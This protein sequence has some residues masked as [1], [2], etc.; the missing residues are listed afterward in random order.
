MTYTFKHIYIFIKVWAKGVVDARMFMCPHPVLTERAAFHRLPSVVT[1]FGVATHLSL[2]ARAAR[3]SRRVG[4]GASM[5]G[6][7]GR[8]EVS[9]ACSEVHIDVREVRELREHES[10]VWCCALHPLVPLLATGSSDTSVRLWRLDGE[11][12]RV[13]RGHTEWVYSVAFDSMG[14]ILCSAGFDGTLRLW[15]VS[16]GESIRVIRRPGVSF[17]SVAFTPG[18]GSYIAAASSEK[19]VRMYRVSDGEI[20]RTLAGHTNSVTCVAFQ[21][22]QGTLLATSKYVC[23]Y[24]CVCV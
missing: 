14:D 9:G 16:T 7:A 1:W 22:P 6:Q 18:T 19:V 24:V 5:R 8:R 11:C 2:L 4:A 17:H 20:A 21:P 23:V 10:H 15:N 12:L 3:P 13:L